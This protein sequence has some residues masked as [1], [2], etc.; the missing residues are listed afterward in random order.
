MSTYGPSSSLSKVILASMAYSAF[1]GTWI[2]L[3]NSTNFRGLPCN[4]LCNAAATVHSSKF[5]VNDIAAAKSTTAS[6]PLMTAIST[7]FP[8]LLAKSVIV[9]R[10]LGT[11]LETV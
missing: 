3:D 11:N 7:L 6:A 9:L 2:P 5:S 1:A 10:C 8:S 4:F